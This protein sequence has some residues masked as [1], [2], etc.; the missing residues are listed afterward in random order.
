MFNDCEFI[1]GKD[2]SLV[3]IVP[4]AVPKGEAI[5]IRVIDDTV[6]FYKS[7]DEL[8]G[9]VVCACAKTLRCL[10]NK[11]RVGIIEAIGGRPSFPIYISATAH[12]ETAPHALAAM[13]SKAA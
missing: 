8:I 10:A 7:A 12:V 9:R 6:S 13:A 2:K 11:K 3:V 5:T 1:L 4:Q